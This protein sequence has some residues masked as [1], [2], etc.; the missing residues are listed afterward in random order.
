MPRIK[1]NIE[2]ARQIRA[3][4]REAMAVPGAKATAEWDKLAAEFGVGSR[5]ICQILAGKA[6]KEPN[7]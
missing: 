4:F 3:K 7:P 6:H 1:L 2:H 5:H